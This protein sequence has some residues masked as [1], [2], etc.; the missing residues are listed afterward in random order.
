MLIFMPEKIYNLVKTDENVQKYNKLLEDRFFSKDM[1]S[2]L[3]TFKEN[4]ADIGEL[5]ET[6]KLYGSIV[7]LIEASGD[8]ALKD[9]FDALMVYGNDNAKLKELYNTS[10]DLET[11]GLAV[12][13]L[14][15]NYGITNSHTHD[16]VYAKYLS[17][18]L[19]FVD[20]AIKGGIDLSDRLFVKY[21]EIKVT[22][23]MYEFVSTPT[24]TL[25]DVKDFL[26]TLN[27]FVAEQRKLIEEVEKDS[28]YF[29]DII[30]HKICNILRILFSSICYNVT[31]PSEQE[32][33]EFVNLFITERKKYQ[34]KYFEYCYANF[35]S[36]FY[37]FYYLYDKNNP[38]A[39]VMYNALVSKLNKAF[40]N[41]QKLVESL[42]HQNYDYLNGF[43]LLCSCVYNL[44]QNIDFFPNQVKLQADFAFSETNFLNNAI[45]DETLCKE[46]GE[47][48]F[49]QVYKYLFANIE[50]FKFREKINKATKELGFI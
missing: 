37:Y 32:Q 35:M 39:E 3:V 19:S 48:G 8:K 22:K 24:K 43:L 28:V 47:L 21:M 5:Y 41:R 42:L 45:K 16:E 17:D 36:E 27:V 46:S 38:Y 40:R 34:F 2:D 9:T 6:K 20:E 25:Q 29:N 1:L 49:Y 7:S 44:Q 15:S 14:F 23:K 4:Y 31:L 10:T 11:K 12:Y 13:G 50:R 33:I 30:N 26:A 18:F